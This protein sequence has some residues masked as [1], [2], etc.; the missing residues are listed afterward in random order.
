MPFPHRL[1][2]THRPRERGA[3][4]VV[5]LI[6]LVVLSVLGVTAYFTATQ[7]ERMAAN[8]RDQLLAFQAAETSLRDC[9]SLL[10]VQGGLPA[11]NGTRGMYTAA[12]GDQ[13]QIVDTLNWSQDSA[14]RV[15]PNAVANVARQPRCIVEQM[16][17]VEE[18]PTDSDRGPLT[19]ESVTVY[20]ITATGYGS[21]TDTTATVQSTLRR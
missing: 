10:T 7:E 18:R 20:R 5:G 1:R 2:S 4:L 16:E 12:P 19:T 6:F 15:L 17:N 9:E 8:T 14:T 11:F 13:A 3:V 21:R